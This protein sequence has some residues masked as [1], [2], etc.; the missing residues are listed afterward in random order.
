MTKSESFHE[1]F[2][3]HLHNSQDES[4]NERRSHGKATRTHGALERP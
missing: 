1:V 3:V 4:L 2:H